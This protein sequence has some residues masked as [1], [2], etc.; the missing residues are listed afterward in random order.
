VSLMIFAW[1]EYIQA[2]ELILSIS[3]T[4]LIGKFAKGNRKSH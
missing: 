2:H 3:S 4:L 1:F